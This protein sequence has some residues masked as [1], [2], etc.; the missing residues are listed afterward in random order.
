MEVESKLLQQL[1]L[2]LNY[3]NNAFPNITA[4]SSLRYLLFWPISIF[5]PSDFEEAH[6]KLCSKENWLWGNYTNYKPREL[7]IAAGVYTTCMAS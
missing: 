1:T 2:S 5:H 3:K 6:T 7:K 4:Y